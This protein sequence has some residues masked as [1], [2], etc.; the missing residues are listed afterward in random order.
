MSKKVG[1]IEQLAHSI[2]MRRISMLLIAHS[3]ALALAPPA[4]AQQGWEPMVQQHGDATPPRGPAVK[5]KPGRSAG[6]PADTPAIAQAPVI[7]APADAVRKRAEVSG[8]ET[9]AAKQYCV[10]I[11]D[12]AADAR[13]AWQ[14]KVLT[15]L[16]QELDKRV[17]L[18][19]A[20][21]A[22]YQKWLT[23]RDEFVKRAQETLVVIYSRMKPDAAAQQLTAMDEETAAAVIIQLD[24]RTASTILNEMEPAQ[25]A[26]LTSTI[27]G[28]GKITP[29]PSANA[30]A[31]GKKS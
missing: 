6:A 9:A 22:E 30:R 28:A 23:R 13:F 17:T 16:G 15:D 27:S 1:R 21:T 31:E 12:A 7:A 24:P 26:R 20:K 2:L 25:A 18:L 14:R 29:N 3:L 5:T 4:L 8:F 10:N 11:A 19:E